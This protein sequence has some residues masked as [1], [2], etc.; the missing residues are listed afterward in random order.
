M[1]E[2]VANT[3][4]QRGQLN[5]SP[6]RQSPVSSGT[7][8]AHTAV[9]SKKGASLKPAVNK[10][11]SV[12][13]DGSKNTRKPD[14]Q[15]K[16]SYYDKTVKS[17]D[18]A[19]RKAED[20]KRALLDSAR[21]LRNRMAGGG[22][23]LTGSISREV[24]DI[25]GKVSKGVGKAVDA[26]TFGTAGRLGDFIYGTKENRGLTNAQIDERER[27]LRKRIMDNSGKSGKKGKVKAQIPGA[28]S[29]K[30]SQVFKNKK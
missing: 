5:L 23:Y 20:G 12:A 28:N 4:R 16:I 14:R 1:A 3:A 29:Y 6:A 15:G 17:R 25:K 27:Q 26:A 9:L 30:D 22:S 8:A 21:G 11:N 13:R 19:D 7:E 24:Y 10:Y 18:A 2:K